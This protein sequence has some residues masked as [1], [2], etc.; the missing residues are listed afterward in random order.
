MKLVSSIIRPEKLAAV[1]NALKNAQVY[2]LTVREVRD[3][4]PQRH[5]TT[6]WMGTVYNLGSTT[7]IEIE[8]VVHD[9]DA[10]AVVRAI[11]T[12]ARTGSEGDGFVSVLP[13]DHRYSIRNGER[14]AS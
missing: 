5:E 12:T 13:V 3:H 4:S 1:K 11:I 2:G 14:V 9:D 7:K 8:V 10:D 6:A